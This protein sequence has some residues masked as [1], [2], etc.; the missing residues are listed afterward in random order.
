MKCPKCN[1]EYLKL[2]NPSG[3]LYYER[4]CKCRQADELRHPIRDRSRK[5]PAARC[6]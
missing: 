1:R 3:R 6:R 4:A 5:Q 2:K